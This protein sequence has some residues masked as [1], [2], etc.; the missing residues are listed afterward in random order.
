MHTLCRLCVWRV[1]EAK[2]FV[3]SLI[4]PVLVV[5]DAIFPLGFHILGVSLRDIFRSGSLRKIVNVHV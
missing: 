3:A 2:N 5:F 4:D 1:C